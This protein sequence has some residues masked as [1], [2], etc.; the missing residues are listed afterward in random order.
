MLSTTTT[1]LWVVP[2]KLN[3]FSWV[4]TSPVELLVN[5][6]LRDFSLRSHLRSIQMSLIWRL[7]TQKRAL[8]ITLSHPRRISGRQ[9]KEKLS[10]TSLCLMAFLVWWWPIQ[11][12]SRVNHLSSTW[13]KS[14]E[15]LHSQTERSSAKTCKISS[16]SIRR[17][18]TICATSRITRLACLWTVQFS[19]HCWELVNKRTWNLF[20]PSKKSSKRSLVTQRANCSKTCRPSTWQALY[21]RQIPDLSLDLW[22]NA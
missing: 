11:I 7:W 4:L 18:Q 21:L 8:K 12:L 10:I 20:Q 14:T 1:S 16:T 5:L 13:L 17:S 3:W 15:Q 2:H 19:S 22:F 6:L 9:M